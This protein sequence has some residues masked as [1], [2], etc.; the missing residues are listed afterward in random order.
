MVVVLAGM[1]YVRMREVRRGACANEGRRCWR[2]TAHSE[3]VQ[4]G[5]ASCAL[6]DRRTFSLNVTGWKGK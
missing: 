6:P 4:L 3:F 2:N 5:A 1:V